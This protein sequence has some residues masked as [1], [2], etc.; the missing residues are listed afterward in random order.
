MHTTLYTL[1]RTR[2]TLPEK[3]YL[4]FEDESWHS[5]FIAP[6]CFPRR[7]LTICGAPRSHLSFAAA[8]QTL[9]CR[10]LALRAKTWQI[11]LNCARKHH[12]R[13]A[14]A[15]LENAHSLK[16]KLAERASR[17]RKDAFKRIGSAVLEKKVNARA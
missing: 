9:Q 3:F 1:P 6:E 10:L 13:R 7:A 12:I 16:F 5:Y 17:L 8:K 4:W 2:A 14:H 11:L 15:A